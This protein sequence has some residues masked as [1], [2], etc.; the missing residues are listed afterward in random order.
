MKSTSP[1]VTL[2]G[3]PAGVTKSKSKRRQSTFS[4][5]WLMTMLWRFIIVTVILV[6]WE[7]AVRLKLVNG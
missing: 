7:S 5:E 6:I 4:K 1:E 3:K 2:A